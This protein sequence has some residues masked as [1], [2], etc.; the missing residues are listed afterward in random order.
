MAEQKLRV[1]LITGR[2]IDQGVG[3]ELGKGSD[4]YFDSVAVCFLDPSDIKKL[5][6]KSGMNVQV[7]SKYG[8]VVVKA[9]KYT[10]GAIP[11]MIFMPCGLWA[12]IICSADTD[13]IGMPT[14]RGF[15]VEVEPAPNKPVLTLDE[16]LKQEFGK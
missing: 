13:S 3:K 5:G 6:L 10:H 16:L 11:G 9:K 7:T 2:T 4:K 12:N 8:S 14:F 1:T 15:T